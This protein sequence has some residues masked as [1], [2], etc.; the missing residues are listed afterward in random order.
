MNYKKV[1]VR[2]V[3][4]LQPLQKVKNVTKS[5]KKVKGVLKIQEVEGV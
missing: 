3:G 1:E 2:K 5:N 4:K